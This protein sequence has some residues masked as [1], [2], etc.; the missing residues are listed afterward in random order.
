M[1]N[2]FERIVNRADKFVSAVN[3]KMNWVACAAALI[4]L[5]LFCVNIV[6]RYLG[7]PIKG[8]NDIAQVIS[9]VMVSFAIGYTHVQKH[10]ISIS[11]LTA[12][13]SPMSQRILA[14]FSNILSLGLV[15][16]LTWQLCALARRIWLSGEVSTTLR[17]IIH[18]FIFAEALGCALLCLVIAVDFLKTLRK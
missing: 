13:L 2:L 17:F 16:L 15:V 10:H 1:S 14:S 12:H 8:S 11:V 9:V 6:L 3:K 18:P 5:I 4:L 7:Y